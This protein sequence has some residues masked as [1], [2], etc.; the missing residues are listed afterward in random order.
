MFGRDEPVREV[1]ER[2][3]ETD[4][5]D[6]ACVHGRVRET[7]QQHAVEQQTEERS[8]HEDR[9]DQRR[10][11]RDA[12]ADVPLVVEVLACETVTFVVAAGRN[13]R[14]VW[15]YQSPGVTEIPQMSFGVAFARMAHGT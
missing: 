8:E 5:A 9:D 2:H 1:R 7:A 12:L 10:H 14:L 15:I 3:Q 6:D 11:D 13:I 4:R